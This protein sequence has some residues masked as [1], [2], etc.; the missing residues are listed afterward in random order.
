MRL[1]Y[2]YGPPGVGKLTVARELAARTDFKLLHNHLTVNLVAALFPYGSADFSRLVRQFRREMFAEAV[3]AEI[4]LVCTGVYLGTAEQLVAIRRMLEPIHASGGQVLFVQLVCEREVW[5]ARVPSESRRVERKLTDPDRAV[6]LFHD[7][8][9]FGV[10]PVGPHLRIDTT[11]LPPADAAAR[12]VEH[13]VLPPIG[14]D[15]PGA[16]APA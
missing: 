8:D 15:P 4:D 6:G 10:M 9:P 16:R 12:I 2:L 1:V 11:E 5:L 13:Y 7:N 14:D 3:R